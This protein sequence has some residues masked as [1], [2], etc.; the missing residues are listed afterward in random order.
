[1]K[2]IYLDNAATTQLDQRV[3]DAMLPYLRENFGNASS[4]HNLGRQAAVAVEESREK[5]AHYIGAEP[6]E[7]IFTSGGTES[8]NSII[9]GV[10]AASEKKHIITSRVE[11][12]AVLHPIQYG[13]KDGIKA[14]YLDCRPTGSVT[15]KQVEEAVTDDTVLVS[16]I[17]VN[18]EIGA[19][20]PISE[21]SQICHE[22]N[23]YLHSD[24][25]QSVGKIPVNVDD[26]GVD[27][28]NISGHK[29]YGPKGVGA[30][31]VRGG[32]KWKPWME[33]GSQERRRRGGTLNVPGIVGL[34]KALELAVDEMEKGQ[35]HI[36]E[37]QQRM[38]MGL[39]ERFPDLI[40]FNGDPDSGIY[41]IVN[42]S[43]P[44]D[45]DKA[46]DGEM[47][48]LNLDVEGIC[49]SNGSACTSGAVEASH[50]LMALG[51]V[52]PT[53]KSSLRF[54]LSKNNTREDV[55]YTL[56]KLDGIVHRMLETA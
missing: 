26:L 12:H 21:I 52:T 47:L 9:K 4:I 39:E 11:H 55:D 32:S 22:K 51:M 24:T 43:F 8:N 46:L 5:I 7:I 31:Y 10:T 44:L 18:N 23:V 20:N 49:C 54:S 6:S 14:T 1:M 35:D 36:K 34:G 17:H 48:L 16:L 33:G 40:A 53:A 27:F 29:I 45:D 50:V 25:V 15:P 3:L 28:M 19:I 42:F 56:E 38:V 13:R 2:S 41:N 30:L 37:L